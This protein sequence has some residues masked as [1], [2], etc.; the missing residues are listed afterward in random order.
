MTSLESE[1][2][3]QKR[4]FE[5]IKLTF[6]KIS[7]DNEHNNTLS[8][9]TPGAD[10]D[11]SLSQ[12]TNTKSLISDLQSKL[13]EFE[14][15]AEKESKEELKEDLEEDLT[16]GG[17]D[18]S[19]ADKEFTLRQAQMQFQLTEYDSDLQRKQS[20]HSKMLDNLSHT[21]MASMGNMEELK[22]RIECLERE[23][24]DLQRCLTTSDRK[25][26]EQKRERLKSLEAQVGELRKRE[27]EHIRMMKL[28]EENE[29]QCEKLKN[30]IMQIKSDRV[31]LIKQM[32]S[33]NDSF[34]RYKSEKEKEVIG[35]WKLLFL[36]LSLR[37]H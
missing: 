3:E 35:N 27:K 9:N 14:Q 4:K 2:E 31:K 12:Q 17:H 19:P 29:K 16:L 11:G 18:T 6:D 34:R 5:E 7:K 22:S 20:L 10:Q 32:K 36:I 30:E 24:E 13:G 25:M 23:K 8:N 1:R 28:K 26:T 15:L 33:D 37:P 21:H